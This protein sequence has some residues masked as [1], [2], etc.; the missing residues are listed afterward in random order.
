[1]NTLS[2]NVSV[3]YMTSSGNEVRLLG[4]AAPGATL[5]LPLQAVHTPTAEIFFSVEGEEIKHNIWFNCLNIL[6]I[7]RKT[8]LFKLSTP[9]R[10]S[11]K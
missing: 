7:K 11:V 3:Y 9:K 1:M 2:V 10:A 8:C 4:E 5:R 6:M